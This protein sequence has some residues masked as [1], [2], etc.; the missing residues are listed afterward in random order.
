MI[1][2]V[3]I[4]PSGYICPVRDTSQQAGNAA[5]LARVSSREAHEERGATAGAGAH[6]MAI[7][8]PGK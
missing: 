5:P 8:T 6:L 2:R 1:D 3:W 4:Q 7:A